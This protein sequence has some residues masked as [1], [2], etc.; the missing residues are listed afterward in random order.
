MMKN[1]RFYVVKIRR[2]RTN[3]WRGVGLT[4]KRASGKQDKVDEALKRYR[5]SAGFKK[6][7]H[8]HGLF[9]DIATMCC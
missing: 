6:N 9:S 7:A 1:C 3:E 8:H 5:Q 2:Q 4:D